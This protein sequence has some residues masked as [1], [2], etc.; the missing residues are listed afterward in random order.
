[1]FAI[2][3]LSL[4]DKD[5]ATGEYADVKS[6]QCC[7]DS[8]AG[9]VL[10]Y[11]LPYLRG[12][13]MLTHDGLRLPTTTSPVSPRFMHRPLD[14]GSVES[15]CMNCFLTISRTWGSFKVTAD[16]LNEIECAHVC[17]QRHKPARP[18]DSN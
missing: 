8:T 1:V 14:N 9:S 16:E 3:I 12:V 6:V 10:P 5:G 18:Q 4:R 7:T 17:D 11:L 2:P 15:I 13:Q